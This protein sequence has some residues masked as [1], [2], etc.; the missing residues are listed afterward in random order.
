MTIDRLILPHS[1]TTIIP[2]LNSY[3]VIIHPTIAMLD[4]RSDGYDLE[5]SS[6]HTI[7]ARH[8]TIVPGPID[9]QAI[10]TPT[11]LQAR[12]ILPPRVQESDVDSS[13]IYFSDDGDSISPAYPFVNRA[14]SPNTYDHDTNDMITF[15]DLS[16]IHI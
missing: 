3:G 11:F 14:L 6:P 4:S 13:I 10:T 1:V 2:E 9:Q 5:E 8:S 12:P 15:D 7:E 16:L